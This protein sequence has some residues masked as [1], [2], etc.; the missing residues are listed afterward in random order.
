MYDIFF[1][2]SSVEEHM[3]SFQLLAIMSKGAMNVV[4]QVSLWC[5]GTYLGYMPRSATTGS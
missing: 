1:I 5:G 2:H 3:G 4:V